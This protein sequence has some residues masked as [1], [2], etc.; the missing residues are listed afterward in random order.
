MNAKNN[1]LAFLTPNYLHNELTPSPMMLNAPQTNVQPEIAIDRTQK[2]APT[3]T[4]TKIVTRSGYQPSYEKQLD[5]AFYQQMQSRSNDVD[6]MRKEADSLKNTPISFEDVNLR[7]ALAYADSL[8]GTNTANYYQPPTNAQDRKKQIQNLQDQ[9]MKNQNAIGD[10]QLN[11]LK[12]KAQE[13]S[14]KKREASAANQLSKQLLNREF[15]LR[16][17]WSKDPITKNSKSIAEGW[18]KINESVSKDSRASDLSLIY[19]IMKLQDPTST[20][21]ESEADMA[22]N[23][24]GMPEKARAMFQSLM[25]QGKLTPEQRQAIVGEATNLYNAQISRQDLLDNEY[26]RLASTY[27]LN[28][29]NVVLGGVL[30]NPNQTSKIKVSNGSETLTID[31]SD[32]QAAIKDGYSQVK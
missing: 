21:R 12:M 28:P 23:I 14:I 27:G 17:E 30:R 20:V 4:T 22:Q 32:L 5:D 1:L 18:Q 15:E 29:K 31:A 24:G 26:Q 10:D 13:E 11:Y 8:M 25:G 2:F 7:P 19:G 9:I 6:N 16:G 3:R